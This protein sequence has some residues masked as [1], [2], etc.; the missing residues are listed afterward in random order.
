MGI[1]FALFVGLI[2]CQFALFVGLICCQTNVLPIAP[3]ADTPVTVK[4][5]FTLTVPIALTPATPVTV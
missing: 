4:D 3:V 2:C 5:W 1:Q